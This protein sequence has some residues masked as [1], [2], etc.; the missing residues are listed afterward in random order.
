MQRLSGLGRLRAMIVVAGAAALLAAAVPPALGQQHPLGDGEVRPGTWPGGGA[1]IGVRTGTSIPGGGDTT[2][3]GGP[4]GGGR[5]GGGGGPA[6]DWRG[7]TRTRLPDSWQ[8]VDGMVAILITCLGSNSYWFDAVPAGTPDPQAPP[9]A[10]Q[11]VDPM[12]LV[13]QALRVLALPSPAI[14]VNPPLDRYQLVD[15]P[16]WLWIDPSAWG[17]RSETA[18]VPG[19]SATVRAVPQKVVWSMGD[20]G[21]VTCDGPGTPYDQHR[22]PGAQHTDCFYTWGVTWRASNGEAGTLPDQTLSATA[23]L[24]VLEAQTIN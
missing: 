16:T 15:L 2:A 21:T 10:P 20:G 1:V 7:C 5:G 8:V 9:A 23:S 22:P 3:G 11:P 4:G 14:R 13:Q 19:L 17:D 6:Y 18:S 24:R 12:T